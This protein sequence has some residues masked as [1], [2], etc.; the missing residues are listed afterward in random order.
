MWSHVTV[1]SLV[2]ALAV[3]TALHSRPALAADEE[4]IYNAETTGKSASDWSLR[5]QVQFL[6]P[7]F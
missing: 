2:I 6:L 3:T 7:K 5:F 4:E 1:I